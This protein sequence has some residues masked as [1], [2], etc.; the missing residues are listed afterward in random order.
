[1]VIIQ[2]LI[3][4]DGKVIQTKVAK[5]LGKNGCDEAA[6]AAIKKTKWKPALQRR[7]PVQVWVN[8]PVN[9]KLNESKVAKD[10][11]SAAGNEKQNE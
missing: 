5:T 10:T 7:K 11:T 2:V 3:A 1:M 8:I 9:F 4:I 6:I